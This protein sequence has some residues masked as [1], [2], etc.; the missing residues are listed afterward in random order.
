MGMDDIKLTRRAFLAATTTTAAIGVVGCATGPN[1]ARVVP[2]KISPNEKAN[3]A[4]I[5]AGGKGNS[6]IMNCRH[7]NVVALCDVDWSRAEEAFYRLPKAKQYKDYR[8]MLD[9]MG[10]EIDACTVSTP[11]HTHAPAAYMAMCRGIHVYVQK[12]LCHTVAETRLLA[13]VARKTG[14]A[15]QM[16]NQGQARDDVRELREMIWS[17][18]IGDIHTVHVW[19]D[20]P[21]KVWP[22]GI[23]EPLPKAPIPRKLEWDLWIG[24]APMRPYNPGYHPRAWRGWWDFGCGALGDMGCHNMNPAWS[25]LRLADAPTYSVE[26]VR[27]DGNNEQ[28]GPHSSVIK[29][30]FPARGEMGAMDLYWYDGGEMPPRPEGVPEDEQ[31]GQEGG[32]GSLFLGDKGVITCGVNGENSRLLPAARMD[33]YKRPDPWLP[34]IPDEDPYRDWLEMART[35]KPACSNFDYSG[36]LS[37]M[38]VLGNVA[39]CRGRKI[40]YDPARGKIIGDRD[41]NQ[42]LTKSYR[43]GWELPV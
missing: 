41:A 24:S 32:N 40:Q 30:H 39:L 16:G 7:E 18:A 20:R 12:P 43:S 38:V 2:R 4:A 26:L 37:E 23:P 35:G 21:G 15:T 17:G 9:E 31:L 29:Y 3:V 19:T 34:R 22:Q 25:A 8:R 1:L 36:P 28:T 10:D 13:E 14:V 6:D 27:E 11:D 33:D 42:M 5:G